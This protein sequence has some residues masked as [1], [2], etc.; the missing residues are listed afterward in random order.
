M[1]CTPARLRFPLGFPA[2]F[3]EEFLDGANLARQELLAAPGD[4]GPDLRILELEVVLEL[5]D[6]HDPSE[7]DAVLLEDHVFLVQVDALDDGVEG[8]AA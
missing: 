1:S 3:I 2:K 4:I 6:V 8:V 5:A 7:R